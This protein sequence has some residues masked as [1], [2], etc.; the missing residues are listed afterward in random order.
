[1]L[2]TLNKKIKSL[3]VRIWKDESAQGMTEYILL[4]VGLVVVLGIF[5]AEFGRT[6]NGAI[7]N[8]TDGINGFISE[9]R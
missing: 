5:R 2:R 7:K 4:V 9:S 8:M 3:A 1:M 6:I